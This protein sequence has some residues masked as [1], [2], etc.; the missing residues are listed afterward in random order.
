LIK[1][2][3][4]Y[5][6]LVQRISENPELSNLYKTDAQIREEALIQAI[7]E[8][9]ATIFDDNKLQLMWN[10]WL[11]SFD[12]FIKKVLGLPM[13]TDI[14]KMKLSEF[15]DMAA[16]EVLTGKGTGVGGEMTIEKT[17]AAKDFEVQVN[18]WQ[19]QQSPTQLSKIINDGI[20][21]KLTKAQIINILVKS[22]GMTTQDATTAYNDVKAGNTVTVTST[23]PA[24]TTTTVKPKTKFVD[25]ISDAIEQ[26]AGGNLAPEVKDAITDALNKG[27]EAVR[28][29]QITER[30]MKKQLVDMLKDFVRKGTFTQKEILPMMRRIAGLNAFNSMAVDNF[31]NFMVNKFETSEAKAKDREVRAKVKNARKNIKSKI[32]VAKD[33]MPTLQRLFSLNPRIIP[34][35]VRDIYNELVIEF[36]ERAGVLSLRNINEVAAKANQILQEAIG[37]QN[38]ALLLKDLFDNFANKV[39]DANGNVDYAKTI[40]QMID[41]GVI[42][43]ADEDIMKRQKKLIFESASRKKTETEIEAERVANIDI[44]RNTPVDVTD[45]QTR[46]ER[47]DANEFVKLIKSDAVDTLSPSQAAMLPLIIDNIN[48][49]WF[50][51][52]AKSLI[53]TMNGTSAGNQIADIVMSKAKAG[54]LN[55]ILASPKTIFKQGTSAIKE[56]SR[57]KTLQYIDRALGIKN[58]RPIYDLAIKRIAEAYTAYKTSYKIYEQK[59]DKAKNEVFKSLGRN[60]NALVESSYKQMAYMLQRE[61]LSN[62]GMKGVSPVTEIIDATIKK[63]KQQNRFADAKMLEDIKEKYTVNGEFDNDLLYNSFNQ[64]EK[65]SIDV[66]TE[67]NND[68][69]SNALYTASVIRGDASPMYRNYIHHDVLVD[70]NNPMQGFNAATSAHNPSTKAVSLIARKGG[71]QPLNFDVFSAVKRSSRN[72]LLD[73]NM[74]QQMRTTNKAMN[75]MVEKVVNDPNATK[76]QIAIATAIKDNIEEVVK[77]VFMGAYN[78][79]TM[80]DEAIDF[81]TK[82]GYRTMLAGV[83]SG[84]ELLSNFAAVMYNPRGFAKGVSIMRTST[85]FDP[86]AVMQNVRSSEIE[87]LYSSDPLTGKYVDSNAVSSKVGAKSE[88]KTNVV[89]NK[90]NQL[91]DYT[92][93]PVRNKVEAVADFLISAPDKVVMRPHWFGSFASEF[94]KITGV[95]PDFEKIAANDEA[96]MN[97]YKESLDKAKDKADKMSVFI[98]ASDNPFKGILK[99]TIRESDSAAVKGYKRFN[100]FM[101]RFLVF[102]YSTA[103]A[104]ITSMF[105]RGELTRSEGAALL[106]A[107]T[108]RMIGYQ[109]LYTALSEQFQG[110]IIDLFGGEEPKEDDRDFAEK[111][112]KSTLS[113]FANLAVGRDLGNASKAILNYSI[114]QFNESYLEDLRDGRKYDKYKD[115]LV[116]SPIPLELGGEEGS[117]SYGLDDVIISLSGPLSP[118]MRTAQKGLELL[119]Q[120]ERKEYYARKRQERNLEERIPLEI[121]GHLG[122]V[123][124]YKDLRAALIK[125]INRTLKYGESSGGGITKDELKKYAPDLYDDIYGATDEIEAEQ[126]EENADVDAEKK[127]QREEFLKGVFD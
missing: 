114:E 112:K 30:E 106:A 14:T 37:E 76:D 122:F 111:L 27:R 85:D 60:G 40:K 53:A 73:F 38:Q 83:R 77:D 68:L 102:E 13:N 81:I 125:D 109:M 79:S 110:I 3:K 118:L 62:I 86:V 78:E 104:A 33:V 71:P 15:L 74:T 47:D 107:I 87:R 39:L 6:E 11:A 75:T 24:A 1:M 80:L 45:I 32:G 58:A 48:N 21:A 115:N 16:T 117:K 23:T 94:K 124:F 20:K 56:F 12:N 7:G 98:G 92:T 29:A 31:V 121:I 127:A 22:G 90:I 5:K 18:A 65:N 66:I 93:R 35:S 10:N 26:M 42:Q 69:T 49:G 64:A 120:E 99:N 41:D 119:G 54:V 4:Y 126:K 9:G 67:V 89:I 36:G 70:A 88:G 51:S 108:I 17:K 28:L 101:T 57:G 46:E 61:Y 97:Q 103:R 19:A 50:P 100:S 43:T 2:S 25:G 55:K 52:V 96:Y 105:G 123:P 84:A 8:R 44:A 34:P 113:A 72:V 95:E 116:Y 59:I 63:L 82:T 91:R